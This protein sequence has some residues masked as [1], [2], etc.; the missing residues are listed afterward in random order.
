MFRLRFHTWH[1]WKK[2]WWSLAKDVGCKKGRVRL[3]GKAES[4]MSASQVSRS[5]GT[6]A[7]DILE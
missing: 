2:V 7:S 3:G 6:R 5:P 1:H 4:W